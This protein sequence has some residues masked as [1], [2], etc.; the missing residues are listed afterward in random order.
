MPRYQMDNSQLE[1]LRDITDDVIESDFVPYASLYDPQTIVT[2]NGELVQVIKIT[3]FTYE[4]LQNQKVDLREVLRQAMTKT[5]GN[6]RYAVW[7]TTMRRKKDVSLDSVHQDGFS[8]ELNDAW[9]RRNGWDSMFVNELYIS[10]VIEAENADMLKK[11]NIRTGLWGPKDR[12][13]RMGYIEA[14]YEELTQTTRQMLQILQP[15]GARQLGLVERN[16]VYYGEHLEFLEKLINLHERPMPVD[17][18]DLSQYLTSG[19]ITFAYNAMEVRSLDETRRFATVMTVKEYKEA[20]LPM[21]DDILHMPIEFI[22]TQTFNFVHGKAALNQYKEQ[23]SYLYI[24]GDKELAQ[25]SELLQIVKSDSGSKADFGEQQTSLF[26]IADSLDE[27]E[28]NTKRLQQAFASVGVMTIREDLKFEECY[29][30]QLPGNFEFLSRLNYVSTNHIAGFANIQNYPAGNAAGTEWGPPVSIFHTAAG[31]PYF[32]NYHHDGIGH[33]ALVGPFGSG[34]TVLL[35][36]LLGQGRST[37]YRLSYLDLTGRSAAFMQA[38]GGRVIAPGKDAKLNP[39][40]LSDTKGNREF[41]A[42]WIGMLI[43]PTGAQIG[44]GLLGFLGEVVTQLYTLPLEQ[45]SLDKVVEMCVQKDPQLGQYLNSWRTDPQKSGLF[46]A[47]SEDTPLNDPLVALDLSAIAENPALLVP[48]ASYALHRLTT[49]LKGDPTVIVLDEGWRLLNNPAF[50]PRVKPWLGY[51][52]SK[53]GLVFFTTEHPEEV[54]DYPFHE[55][56]RSGIRTQFFMPDET[57]GRVYHE[58]FGLNGDEIDY[59]QAMQPENRHFLMKRADDTVVTALNLSGMHKMLG[60][61]SGTA[62]DPQAQV[63]MDEDDFGEEEEVMW[64]NEA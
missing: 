34:K 15:Y 59:L 6:G 56:I 5:L 4:I 35:H 55:A 22:V 44:Q 39:F 31:T 14:S 53:N 37:P 49:Q 16:G 21:I 17:K 60:I 43:D 45:R 13:R 3:G 10:V 54:L 62:Q 58:A 9:T 18:V 38:I 20:T 30:A 25:G 46:A 50:A 47:G 32:Y 11:E 41:L 8:Q 1:K 33:T 19:E 2:K 7:M 36:F 27:L 48:V 57:A 64:E 40:S 51:I 52:T 23:I 61:L 63:E 12:K 42:L 26:I 29:W 28:E 24:S